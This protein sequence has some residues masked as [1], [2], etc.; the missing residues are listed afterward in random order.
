MRRS[1]RAARERL[2]DE[3]QLREEEWAEGQHV[4]MTTWL[5]RMRWRP[6]VEDALRV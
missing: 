4:R 3:C 5:G 2:Q 6:R 1:A